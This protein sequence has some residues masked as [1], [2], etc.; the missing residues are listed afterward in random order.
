MDASANYVLSIT[1][2]A[3]EL[4]VSIFDESGRLVSYVSREFDEPHPDE[5][6]SAVITLIDG[7]LRHAGITPDDLTAIGMAASCFTIVVWDGVSGQPIGSFQTPTV[8]SSFSAEQKATYVLEEGKHLASSMD[9]PLENFRF[10]GVHTWLLWNLSQGRSYKIDDAHDLMAIDSPDDSVTEVIWHSLCGLTPAMFPTSVAEPGDLARVSSV[11]LNGARTMISTLTSMPVA[12]LIGSG[13]TASGKAFI[14]YGQNG[15]VVMRISNKL[16]FG[17]GACSI[18]KARLGMFYED[19]WIVLARFSFAQTL[20]LWM[21]SVQPDFSEVAQTPLGLMTDPSI[22]VTPFLD[23]GMEKATIIGI[24]AGTPF[25][26]IHTAALRSMA[27]AAAEALEI[28]QQ[29]FTKSL[30]MICVERSGFSVPALFWFQAGI[31]TTVVIERERDAYARGTA[32]L[33]GIGAKLW[34]LSQGIKRFEEHV[35]SHRYDSP[36]GGSRMKQQRKRWQKAQLD[37]SQF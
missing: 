34:T 21:Q 6:L 26:A 23:R 5:L 30:D 11:Y 25:S 19:E 15:F 2:Q 12:G 3:E 13:I 27:F 18:R 14:N 29:N 16:P 7:A 8:W 1:Q 36:E 22:F 31:S 9:M 24:D 17:H 32:I 33:S 37:F 35:A 28:M 10:G 4:G 20:L